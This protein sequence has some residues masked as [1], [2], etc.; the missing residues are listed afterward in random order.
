MED[1]LSLIPNFSQQKKA[2]LLAESWGAAGR[3]GFNER[4]EV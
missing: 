1:L 3:L 2:E 4:E